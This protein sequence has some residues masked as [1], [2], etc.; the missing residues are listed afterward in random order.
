MHADAH[1][2]KPSSLLYYCGQLV[3][4]RERAGKRKNVERR[5]EREREMNLLW[6][7]RW[8][9]LFNAAL[10]FSRSPLSTP[11]VPLHYPLLFIPLPSPLL[12]CV[13]TY[14]ITKIMRPIQGMTEIEKD[15]PSTKKVK[16]RLWREGERLRKSKRNKRG[17]RAEEWKRERQIEKKERLNRWIWFIYNEI[18]FRLHGGMCSIQPFCCYRQIYPFNILKI[19]VRRYM[20]TI[21]VLNR[22]SY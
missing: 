19:S 20:S 3:S 18:S 2:A 10:L 5:T 15:R 21:R 11:P 14:Y 7:L 1:R 22:C 4:E 16:A 9:Q 17:R 12:I 13:Q 8:T 6:L